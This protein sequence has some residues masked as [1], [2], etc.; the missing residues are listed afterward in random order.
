MSNVSGE[1]PKLLS[2]SCGYFKN[3]VLKILFK[4]KDKVLKYLLQ[5]TKGRIFDVLVEYA[6]E[7]YSIASLLMEIMQVNFTS[8]DS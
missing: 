8:L 2:V 3:I 1:K 6:G 5:T 4:Q 7:H